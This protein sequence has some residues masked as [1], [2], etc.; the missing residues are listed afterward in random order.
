MNLNTFIFFLLSIFVWGAK[1]EIP[2]VSEA[3]ARYAGFSFQGGER[4]DLSHLQE[5]QNMIIPGW[6]PSI[7]SRVQYVA[8]SSAMQRL[9]ELRTERFVQ[10]LLIIE[11]YNIDLGPLRE[12]LQNIESLNEEEILEIQ[13]FVDNF[14]HNDPDSPFTEMYELKSRK[15]IIYSELIREGAKI[16]ST[17]NQNSSFS[18][19]FNDRISRG[20]ESK[21]EADEFAELLMDDPNWNE[22][23][24]MLNEQQ[25]GP[26][27]ELDLIVESLN[28]FD[29][30]NPLLVDYLNTTWDLSDHLKDYQSTTE[31]S[32]NFL[33]LEAGFA[34]ESHNHILRREVFLGKNGYR[35]LG[36]PGQQDN[37]IHFQSFDGELEIYNDSNLGAGVF[38]ST[39]EERRSNGFSAV[40]SYYNSSLRYLYLEDEG[41]RIEGYLNNPDE[42][43]SP[44]TLYFFSPQK[45]REVDFSEVIS[46]GN[47]GQHF[48]NELIQSWLSTEIARDWIFQGG[49]LEKVFA[50]PESLEIVF[51]LNRPDNDGVEYYILS[52]IE[53]N[54]E[55]I[56]E[57]KAS[58]RGEDGKEQFSFYAYFY[59]KNSNRNQRM[60]KVIRRNSNGLSERIIYYNDQGEM[61]SQSDS[62]TLDEIEYSNFDFV[63]DMTF[64]YNYLAAYVGQPL[65]LGGA[66]V[67]DNAI[68]PAASTIGNFVA[69]GAEGFT[70]SI[71]SLGAIGIGQ[72]FNDENF[73]EF[74]G[75]I[76]LGKALSTEE[77]MRANPIPFVRSAL[78]RFNS[79]EREFM[80]GELRA[81]YLQYL[82]DQIESEFVSEVYHNRRKEEIRQSLPFE[83][84]L[85]DSYEGREQFAEFVLFHHA[86]HSNLRAQMLGQSFLGRVANRGIGFSVKLGQ[87][88]TVL[89][90]LKVIRW[91][92]A[93]TRLQFLYP[94]SLG[95]VIG[96]AG[97]NLYEAGKLA[98]NNPAEYGEE[99]AED[100]LVALLLYKSAKSS[101]SRGSSLEQTPRNPS[102]GRSLSSLRESLNRVNN[103][104]KDYGYDQLRGTGRLATDRLM[105]QLGDYKARL[106]EQIRNHPD[107]PNHFRNIQD[108][109]NQKLG[110]IENL[111]EQTRT[112]E[113]DLARL[114]DEAKPAK[115]HELMETQRL[116]N[117]YQVQVE[118]LQ[119][120][121]SG[122]PTSPGNGASGPAALS[123]TAHGP[124]LVLVDHNTSDGN[125]LSRLF[126]F[127]LN[128]TAFSA[129]TMEKMREVEEAEN[130]TNEQIDELLEQLESEG[131]QEFEKLRDNDEG[132]LGVG[133]GLNLGEGERHPDISDSIRDK[134]FE[135]LIARI[136]YSDEI[137]NE[138]AEYISRIG[139]AILVISNIRSN[140][141]N[142][143]DKPFQRTDKLL[144]QLSIR[145]HHQRALS[146]LESNSSDQD[147]LEEVILSGLE[148]GI[149]NLKDGDKSLVEQIIDYLESFEIP[150]EVPAEITYP[151]IINIEE[152]ISIIISLEESGE[153]PDQV[154]DYIR[155]LI[156]YSDDIDARLVSWEMVRGLLNLNRINSNDSEKA[157]EVLH[158]L[159]LVSQLE[160]G[161]L[162]IAAILAGHTNDE[163]D[164]ELEDSSPGQDDFGLFE[165]RDM[166]FGLFDGIDMDFGQGDV[167]YFRAGFPFAGINFE[168][169]QM[170]DRVRSLVHRA[171]GGDP[172]LIERVIHEIERAEGVERLQ[173]TDNSGWFNRIVNRARKEL[174]NIIG[175]GTNKSLERLSKI[176]QALKKVGASE[177]LSIRIIERV[178]SD[179][180]VSASDSGYGVIQGIQKVESELVQL[181]ILEEERQRIVLD[182]F[183]EAFDHAV[184]CA[185]EPAFDAV[186]SEA[187]KR[188]LPSDWIRGL[189]NSLPEDGRG[190]EYMAA[191]R[192]I[193]RI[194]LPQ[195]N[196]PLEIE[197]ISIMVSRLTVH[198]RTVVPNWP[199]IDQILEAGRGFIQDS[200]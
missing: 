34:P 10:S 139:F 113:Q 83:E 99:F 95:L 106:E 158:V 86:D 20:F 175:K 65:Y 52:Q 116:I 64:K 98:Y 2:S 13:G 159:E 44:K 26:M 133:V 11:E 51:V 100:L 3:L 67:Y 80:L 182:L 200:E 71:A 111:R 59:C 88:A 134:I 85:L 66:Y 172:E 87:A 61:S 6:V 169:L 126:D 149:F 124:P 128:V 117:D 78:D 77:Y 53:E 173:E 45:I 141:T 196:A 168:T 166:D 36:V 178:K 121:M 57:E 92:V 25:A 31:L 110:S 165:D 79:D 14:L 186:A 101:F 21:E 164:L 50:K 68:R 29:E 28:E 82:Y 46:L 160:E 81:E 91:Q 154:L 150:Y 40:A 17:L 177:E 152:L 47:P 93:G 105:N 147:S 171:E 41:V 35:I 153:N 37:A 55:R 5:Y 155:K 8:A 120:Q 163:I 56:L 118:S 129:E 195:E 108:Q 127:T 148:L 189:A 18:N 198:S 4:Q 69:E 15:L 181:G 199:V 60:R 143:D 75:H 32:S 96:S 109:I 137:V 19:D 190:K 24:E 140:I 151:S 138:T 115:L 187:A 9:A 114:P 136:D 12:K 167:S 174:N 132:S 22:A 191:A 125:S 119:Q 102:G 156:K 197:V 30:N 49:Y 94:T 179:L 72:L 42:T 157:K 180:E 193:R 192:M 1:A 58:F 39:L 183:R 145:G 162:L 54:G 135:N 38:G 48:D 89:A 146:S 130:P 170:D 161:R 16:L 123:R 7:D 194:V 23:F 131:V 73:F 122:N 185:N 63:W 103:V 142:S 33:P 74:Y 84:E 76:E 112:L 70:S 176:I 144:N 27:A 62:R 90:G 184:A 188:D 104:L 97:V 107:T 43:R